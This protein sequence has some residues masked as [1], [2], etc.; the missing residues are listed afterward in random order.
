M[1]TGTKIEIT[2]EV[3]RDCCNIERDLVRIVKSPYEN[4]L[5]WF[6]K[7]CGRH[8]YERYSKNPK[9]GYIDGN[10]YVASWEPVPFPWEDVTT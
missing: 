8:W 10:P 9:F 1:K 2:E 6:C 4:S 7:H 3:S 5:Y